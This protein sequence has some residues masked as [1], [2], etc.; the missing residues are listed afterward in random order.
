VDRDL[1]GLW[2]NTKSFG[3]DVTVRNLT[4]T[5]DNTTFKPPAQPRRGIGNGPVLDVDRSG[6]SS[7]GRLYVAFVDGF[8]FPIPASYTDIYLVWSDDQG[9]TWTTQSGSGNVAGSA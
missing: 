8:T 5:Y 2:S 9:A 3:T 4:K 6:S 7:N 1:D